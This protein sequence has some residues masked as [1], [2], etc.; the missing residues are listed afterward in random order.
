MQIPRKVL[1]A[2]MIVLAV[3][4][5]DASG[6]KPGGAEG[7]DKKT[8]RPK[9]VIP[10]EAMHASRGDVSAYFETTTRVQAK[11]QVEVT[12]EGVG[13]CLKVHVDEGDQVKKGQ[14]LAELDKDEAEAAFRQSQVNMKQQEA[15][16]ARTKKLAGEDGFLV[17][18]QDL[19]AARYS[20]ENAKAGLETQRVQLA[21][22]TVRAPIGGVVTTRNIQVGMLV[23]SGAPVFKIVDPSSFELIINPPEKDLPRLKIDQ[24][25]KF[26]VDSVSN[27]EFEARILRI[28]PS[29]DATTGTVKVTLAIDSATQK[30][31]RESAFARVKLIMETHQNALLLPKDA[32]IEENAR[33]F[34][35]A[36]IEEVPE[37]E[38]E[39]EE[40]DGEDTSKDEADAT[41]DKDEPADAD[42]ETAEDEE[43]EEEDEGPFF[44][45]KRIEVITGLED[46]EFTE[47]VEG[48]DAETLVITLGQMTLKEGTRVSVTTAEAEL[49]KKADLTAEDALKAAEE[50]RKKGGGKKQANPR[51]G[52]RH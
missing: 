31:L 33:K 30:K 6:K 3:A 18:L 28:N 11:Q 7:A 41:T 26:S 9:I 14:V 35:F 23:S 39:A 37:P 17:S 5:C 13:K 51:R 1:T 29:V 16:Y 46:S 32:V 36:V 48:I 15:A 38:D 34:V 40:G 10:V 25:A 47:I 27:E 42:G 12:S 19:D 21:N 20:Y 44:E 52:G 8:K 24:V 45:A 22:L 50:A 43:E 49:A 2:L 4:G